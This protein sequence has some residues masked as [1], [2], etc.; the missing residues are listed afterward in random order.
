[1]SSTGMKPSICFSQAIR[2]FHL[3]YVK[4]ENQ[5]S[6][7]KGHSCLKKFRILLQSPAEFVQSSERPAQRLKV[8]LRDKNFNTPQR[9]SNCRIL[10]MSRW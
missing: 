3:A 4:V 10:L 1:M 5:Q 7:L 6:F 8:Y 2:C 9:K